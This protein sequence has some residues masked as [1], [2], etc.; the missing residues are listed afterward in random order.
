MIAQ[1]RKYKARVMHIRA[2]ERFWKFVDKKEEDECW[3]WIGPVHASN[4]WEHGT[5]KGDPLCFIKGISTST[6]PQR[7]AYEAAGNALWLQ[8]KVYNT[9]GN[10][11]CCNPRHL[12]P[13]GPPEWEKGRTI[14]Q[15]EAQANIDRLLKKKTD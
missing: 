1:K 5:R 8:C 11:A 6:N 4:D 9:C 14:S 2:R 13:K 7:I 3:P 10:K 15:A 12:Y